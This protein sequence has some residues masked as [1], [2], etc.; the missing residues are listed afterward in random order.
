MDNL[1]K[2]FSHHHITPDL[3]RKLREKR[4]ENGLTAA[5]LGDYL[6]VHRS[7]LRNW[8]R[9]KFVACRE[10]HFNKLK[11]F[12]SDDFDVRVLAR[13]KNQEKISLPYLGLFSPQ[14]YK[15]FQSQV[16]IASLCSDS[17]KSLKIFTEALEETLACCRKEALEYLLK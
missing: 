6:G 5:D 3:S 15:C 4:L 17:Q 16:L 7:T 13:K 9:G 11:Q 12:L 8:E 1:D 2:L 14:M 10:Y